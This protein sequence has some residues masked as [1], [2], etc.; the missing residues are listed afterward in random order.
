[1][2]KLDDPHVLHNAYQ[3]N[4]PYPNIVLKDVF[5]DATLLQAS[6]EFD[7]VDNWKAHN[8]NHVANKFSLSDYNEMGSACQQIIDSM[9][10]PKFLD[11][12]SK[13]TGY[14]SLIADEDLSG[15]G[16]HK[17]TNGGYLHVH[18]DFNYNK[19][20]K[21]NRRVNAIVF[22]N[23]NWELS[24][25]GELELWSDERVGKRIYP[26]FGDLAIFNTTDAYHGHPHPLKF[27]DGEDRKG[28]S[29]YYYQVGK[30]EVEPHGTIYK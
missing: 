17:T 4:K 7:L 16:L 24:W 12:L 25:H 10:T 20:M 23:P 18:R 11:W 29:L 5:N 28:I 26:E 22:L 13:M 21:A 2:I 8:H 15:G 1:M 19:Y 14:R 30:P 27:P 3:T 6:D 9:S